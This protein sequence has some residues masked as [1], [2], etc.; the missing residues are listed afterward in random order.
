MGNN[1]LGDRR[2]REMAAKIKERDRLL[3][4]QGYKVES[5]FDDFSSD[6]GVD[7]STNDF[8]DSGYVDVD[9]RFVDEMLA[10]KDISSKEKAEWEESRRI[11]RWV[12]VRSEARKRFYKEQDENPSEQILRLREEYGGW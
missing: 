8:S 3:A 10:R 11:G 7:P 2:R 4:G 5:D 9:N 12:G 1:S 6:G